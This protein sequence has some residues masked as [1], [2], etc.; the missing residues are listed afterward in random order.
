MNCTLLP[1]E[2]FDDGSIECK[3][4]CIVEPND[5]A[6]VCEYSYVLKN[7]ADK[8]ALIQAAIK[9]DKHY[10]G[11]LIPSSDPLSFGETQAYCEIQWD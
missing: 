11:Y 1:N 3:T 9:E 7:H 6:L 4:F 5:E 2:L 10:I 8:L